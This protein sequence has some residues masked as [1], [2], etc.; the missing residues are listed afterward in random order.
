MDLVAAE[1]SLDPI[2]CGLKNFPKP[3]EFPF[4]TP[5]GLTYDSGNYQ[6]ALRKV[7]VSADG[8]NSSNNAKL[9]AKPDDFSELA[10]PTYVESA[11]GPVKMMPAGGWEWGVSVSR[12][13]ASN[14]HYRHTPTVRARKLRYPNHR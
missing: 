3:T 14:R 7:S 1:L 9:L 12:S 8:T 2:K 10:F 5:T 6:R 11:P 4:N 13:P